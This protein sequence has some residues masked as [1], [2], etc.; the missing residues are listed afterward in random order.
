MAD[1]Q[2]FSREFWDRRYSSH[3]HVWSGRPNLHLVDEV[4]GLAPGRALDVGCGEGAD[5]LW[6]AQRGWTVTGADVS[7]VAL[8]K[9]AAHVASAA[10]ELAEQIAWREVDLFAPDA[11]PL[12]DYDLI[13]SQY[14]H[15]PPEVRGR[16]LA[17]LTAG[18]A[19]G[20][21]LLLVSHHPSDLEIPGLRPPEPDL[22]YTPEQLVE[23][24]D[25]DHWAVLTAAAPQREGRDRAGNPVTVRDTVVFARRRS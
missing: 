16:A 7:P 3:D 14:L 13:S 8:R 21:H 11:E 4:Q 24:L 9:A 17:R 19:A 5:V 10:P 23:M 1:L 12:G 22:F 20:G 25:G 15:M 18:V 6:L 2:R